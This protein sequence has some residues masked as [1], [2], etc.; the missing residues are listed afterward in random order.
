M[1]MESDLNEKSEDEDD[2]NVWARIEDNNPE[3]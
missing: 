1:D 3:Y 2:G